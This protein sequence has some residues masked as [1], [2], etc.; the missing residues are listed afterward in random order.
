MRRR[1]LLAGLSAGL[2]AGL[3][4]CIG[5]LFEDWE[6]RTVSRTFDP[7]SDRPIRLNTWNGDV[8]VSTH[9]ADRIEIA[10]TFRAYDI[11]RLEELSLEGITRDSGYLIELIGSGATD[12]TGASLD[13]RLPNTM[14]IDSV[15]TNN[16]DIRVIDVPGGGRFETDN[17]DVEV[18]QVNTALVRTTNGDA[19]VRGVDRISGVHTTNGDLTVDVPATIS[20]DVSLTTTNG[21]VTTSL[22]PDIDAHL[23]AM[24]E[25]GDISYQGPPLIDADI[26][27]DY[28]SGQLGTGGRELLVET[29]NGDID[30]F[31]L[32]EPDSN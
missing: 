18:R 16:G 21:D 12:S 31:S 20:G 24:T 29:T 3:S 17:G 7:Q 28:I 26:E 25:T 23:R 13:V 1:T 10:V 11:E 9:T 15:N 27:T 32:A 6:T 8:S 22:S 5:R 30:L 2:T 14:E 4:G 19:T